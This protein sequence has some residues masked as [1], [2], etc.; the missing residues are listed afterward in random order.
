M[1]KPQDARL[2]LASLVDQWDA[3][4]DDPNVGYDDLIDLVEQVVQDA[5]IALGGDNTHHDSSSLQILERN[6]R[7]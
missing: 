1:A 2:I 6:K 5:R 4:R 3:W 7:T